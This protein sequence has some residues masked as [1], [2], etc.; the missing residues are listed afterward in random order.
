MSFQ[1]ALC[2][3][4]GSDSAGADGLADSDSLEKST[5]CISQGNAIKGQ[6]KR[7][8]E[9][10]KEEGKQEQESSTNMV[11]QPPQ[12]MEEQESTSGQG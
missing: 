7:K 4:P 5:A 12:S 9:C 11:A 3:L 10:Y 1:A 2:S 6:G 8:G